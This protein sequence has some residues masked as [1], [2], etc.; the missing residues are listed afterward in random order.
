MARTA[1]FLTL[2][3]TRD[4]KV[5]TTNTYFSQFKR[6][7]VQG[8]GAST[9]GSGEGSRPS[10]ILTWPSLAHAHR[11]ISCLFLFLLWH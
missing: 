8:Q 1:G 10:Y 11:E 6:L 4:W 7:E 2:H 3:N 9:V 5:Q